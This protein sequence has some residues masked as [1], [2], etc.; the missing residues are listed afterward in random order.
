MGVM[1]RAGA[2]AGCSWL[3]VAAFGGLAAYWGLAIAGPSGIPAVVATLAVAVSALGL[4]GALWTG[5]GGR[6]AAVLSLVLGLAWAAFFLANPYSDDVMPT[7][8]AIGAALYGAAISLA[9]AFAL[10]RKSR[11]GSRPD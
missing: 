4:A 2:Y 9:S 6:R 1:K 8:G 11:S 3:A 5:F 10:R 7:S